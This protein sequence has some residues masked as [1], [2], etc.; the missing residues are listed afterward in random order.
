MRGK[1][2]TMKAVQLLG[3]GDLDQLVYR[4]VPVPEPGPGQVLVKVLGTSV[5][6]VDWKLRLG[7]LKQFM[8][9]EFPAIL[10]R[11]LAGEVKTTGKKVM[12]ICSG[13]YAEYV[14]A[15]EDEL[16][17]VPE[18]LSMEQAAAIPLVSITG[19]KLIEEGMNVT[20]GQ[21]ILVTGALGGVGRTA[22][23]VAK[24]HGATVIA[25]VR[26]RQKAEAAGI[27]ADQVVAIDSDEEIKSLPELDGIADLVGG[28][29]ILKLMGKIKAGGT[30]GLVFAPPVGADKLN[31][32]LSNIYAQPNP[33]R[34]SQLGQAVADGKLKIPVAKTFSL[35]DAATAQKTAQSGSVDGKIVIVP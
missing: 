6:P 18:G 23:F 24:Q 3:Y 16:S 20:S 9:L 2:V 30:L 27:G 10:G 26:G 5:N 31:I 34:L 29:P 15:T 4:D 13:T 19:A 14:V 25:G 1:E 32:K 7:Y 8:P 33:A 22:V 28:E 17:P 35:S 12:G 21:T 11:D